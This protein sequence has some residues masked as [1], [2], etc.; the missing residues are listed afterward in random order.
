MR[1]ALLL[2][3]ACAAEPAVMPDARVCEPP[4]DGWY[5]QSDGCVDTVVMSPERRAELGALRD[6]FVVFQA[7]CATDACGPVPAVPPMP[8]TDD[9]AKWMAWD[10]EMTRVAVWA[11]CAA[12]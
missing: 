12:K 2:L 6:A 3:A 7:D 4:M 8:T 5:R 1:A 9:C 10:D 11:Q